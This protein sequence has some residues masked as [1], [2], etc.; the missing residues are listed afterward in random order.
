[1]V[2]DVVTKIRNNNR[3]NIKYFH[4]MESPGII[5]TY[6]SAFSNSGGGTIVFGVK[7]EGVLLSVKGVP[8]D[9]HINKI[10]NDAVALVDGHAKFKLEHLIIDLRQIICLF[11]ENNELTVKYKE[12]GYVMKAGTLSPEVITEKKIFLS[13]CQNDSCIANIVE[14]MIKKRLP[15]ISISRDIRDVKYK[16]SFRKFMQTIGEHDFVIM[17]VS[18]QYLKSR[19]CMY[20]V[21]EVMRDRNFGRKLLFIVISEKDII[22]Y[23][24]KSININADIYSTKGQTSYIKYWQ[25]VKKETENQISEIA[26]PMLSVEQAKEL[27]I[28]TKI[29]IDIQEFMGYLRDSKG[30]SLADMMV[31]DFDNIVSCIGS[32]T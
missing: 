20:E 25:S 3:E 24:D 31:S 18:D 27:Q 10:I 7:D 12:H 28:I 11:I 13:Y 15:F 1:M 6:I 23:D 19:N 4:T 26:D 2:E 9:F 22:Y 30:I 5:A 21:L 17:L 29:L 8:S 16:E 14:R 32:N